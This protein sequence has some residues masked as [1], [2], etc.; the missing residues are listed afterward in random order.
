MKKIPLLLLLMPGL[1]L[2]D[3]VYLKGGG[4]LTGRITEQTEDRVM[5]D[6]GDGSVGVSMDRVE[7]I[8]KGLSPLDEFDQR[9]SKLEQQ[10]SDGWRRLA[11]WA[12]MK[13][14]SSQSRMAY[15]R[16]VAVAPDDAEARQA[17]GFVRLDGRWVTEEESYRARGYVKYAGEW[18]TP[19]EVQV[20]QSTDAREQALDAAQK[21]ASDAEFAATQSR[22][23]AQDERKK[24]QEAESRAQ[25]A[26][27]WR[28][29]TPVYWGG[30]GYSPV[31]PPV[32]VPAIPPAGVPR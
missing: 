26:Q 23:R 30:W 6:V 7:Q 15:Q 29:T 1:L 11:Q 22:L 18:M 3:V 13:G 17:L 31:V 4:K 21:R 9:A 27:S 20:A 19:A 5:V 32:Y 24:A 2:A 10:D 28:N 8:V 25:E 14:L 16:V 12:S